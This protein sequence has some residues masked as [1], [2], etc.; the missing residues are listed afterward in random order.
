MSGSPRRAPLAA[1][2]LAAG[3][4]TR[5]KSGRPK[6]LHEVCGRPLAY[7]PVRRA[8]EAG[9]D[10]VV[11]VVGH[12]AGAVKDVLTGALGDERL[13]FA[14]QRPQRGTAHA[15][16]AAK[17][18]L[19]GF[20]GEVLILSGDTPLLTRETLSAAV[21]LLE[22]RT[23]YTQLGDWP[24]WLAVAILPVTLVARARRHGSAGGECAKL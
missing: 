13:R 11:V 15:V 12:E 2:V 3:K 1:I 14:V 6:V 21:P 18:A 22:V 23:L 17:K 19:R 10:P 9:A 7:Y 5:M 20:A 16:L 8:L 4:G 24:G